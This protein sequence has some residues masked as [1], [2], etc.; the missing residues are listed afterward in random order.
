MPAGGEESQEWQGTQT[1]LLTTID[2]ESGAPRTTSLVYSRHGDRLMVIAAE[3]DS[4]EPPD[5]YRDLGAAP[6][7]DVEIRGE[8]FRARSRPAAY[9]EQAQMWEELVRDWP[10]YARY[11]DRKVPVIVLEPLH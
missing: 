4:S 9:A 8:T 2:A 3:G 6:E 7:A 5:W 11:R 1:L 10:D